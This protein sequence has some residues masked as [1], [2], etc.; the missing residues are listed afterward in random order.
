MAWHGMAWLADTKEEG[1]R[2][3]GW[4]VLQGFARIFELSL[5]HHPAFLYGLPRIDLTHEKH[6]SNLS[7]IC[8]MDPRP[9]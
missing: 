7:L 1:F 3:V 9:C 2:S 8:I 5:Q 6:H 4:K